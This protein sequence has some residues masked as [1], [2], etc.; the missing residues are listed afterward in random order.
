MVGTSIALGF[1]YGRRRIGV[2]VGS[3][4]SGST[5]PLDWVACRDGKPDWAAIGRLVAEWKPA[6][7]VV[8]LPYN[9]DGSE[10]EMSGAARRFGNRLGARFGLPVEFIDERLSSREAGARLLEQRRRGER[11]RLR[12]HH[13][14][15]AAAA[16]ILQS[17]LDRCSHR[18]PDE[19]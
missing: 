12:K 16:V 19:G 15:E 14:D 10:S 13:L 1:D 5:E 6:I 18:G 8:G 2:A 3:R 7:L 9:I 17:W 4:A 11:G